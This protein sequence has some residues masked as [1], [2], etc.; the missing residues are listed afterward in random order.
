MTTQEEHDRIWNKA[1]KVGI[2]IGISEGR[3]QMIEEY[4]RML[5]K[6][7]RSQLDQLNSNLPPGVFDSPLRVVGE[8]ETFQFPKA[9]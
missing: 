2:E 9:A 6:D 5:T 1:L 8:D 3:V 4:T 7:D